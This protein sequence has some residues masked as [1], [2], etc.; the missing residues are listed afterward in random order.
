MTAG[1][2]RRAERPVG[3]PRCQRIVNRRFERPTGT[4]CGSP[5]VRLVVQPVTDSNDSFEVPHGVGQAAPHLVV[6]RAAGQG[7]DRRGGRFR[8]S[9]HRIRVLGTISAAHPLPV[10][11][12]PLDSS[13]GLHSVAVPCAQVSMVVAFSDRCVLN[14]GPLLPSAGPEGGPEGRAARARGRGEGRRQHAA[15]LPGSAGSG[16][17]P[18]AIAVAHR[19]E[20]AGVLLAAA[21]SV[22]V[23]LVSML[24]SRLPTPVKDMTTLS[25]PITSHCLAP[26]RRRR[27][28][29]KA[30]SS[31]NKTCSWHPGAGLAKAAGQGH[32]QRP[33]RLRHAHDSLRQAHPAASRFHLRAKPCKQA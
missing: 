18:P 9:A 8:L 10:P 19:E 4:K 31:A 28:W 32:R 15:G 21:G 26:A 16:G 17:A 23:V 30:H 2:A 6:L 14:H 24:R 1:R 29:H 20:D 3:W 11:P 7:H 27:S 22:A 25:P 12:V 5:P 33:G 13:G